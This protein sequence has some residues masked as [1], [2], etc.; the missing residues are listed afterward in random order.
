LAITIIPQ[1]CFAQEGGWDNVKQ[2][3]QGTK[4]KL[5][6]NDGKSYRG[7]LQSASD[8]TPSPVY[9]KTWEQG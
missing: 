7:T 5:A 4:V 1:L 3:P 8:V 6:L 2:L 9:I